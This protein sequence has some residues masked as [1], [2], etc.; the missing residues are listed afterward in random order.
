[1]DRERAE[2]GSRSELERPTSLRL[3]TSLRELTTRADE[4]AFSTEE[5]RLSPKSCV[6]FSPERALVR[7]DRGG[8]AWRW[9]KKQERLPPTSMVRP[10]V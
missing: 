8:Y 2:I 5:F 3:L 4:F 1:M 9:D 7:E 6:F 10:H